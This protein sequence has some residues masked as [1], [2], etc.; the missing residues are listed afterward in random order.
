MENQPT[1]KLT[2]DAVMELFIENT[3]PGAS[4]AYDGKMFETFG[5]EVAF[6]KA[7]PVDRIATLLDCDGGLYI[8]PGYHFV[9]RVGYFVAKAPLPNFDEVCVVEPDDSD[10]EDPENAQG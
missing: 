7:Q 10:D 2:E 8:V 5:D 6:V 4:G 1:V 9:N 3:L